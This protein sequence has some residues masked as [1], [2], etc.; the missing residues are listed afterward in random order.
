MQ[1]IRQMDQDSAALVGW[2][3]R[4]LVLSSGED[5]RRGVTA[6][7]LSG[8]GG[9][10]DCET[11]MFSALGML[12]DDPAGYGLFVMECDGFGGEEAGRR[13]WSMLGDIVGR[14]PVIL[15]T[16]D[17]QSQLFPEDRRAPIVLRA[18][19]SA[20]SLRV[21]FEHAMRHRVMWHAI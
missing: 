20:V 4:V 19:L 12:I 6:R 15:V 14:V 13:A 1:F 5:A 9:Q 16:R 17:C 3:I 7:R 21:G 2:G 11:E 10:V 18:P 8:L